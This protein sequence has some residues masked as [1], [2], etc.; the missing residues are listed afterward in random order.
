MTLADRIAVLSGGRVMQY[1]TPDEIYHRPAAKFVA[2]FTGSPAMNFLRG[3]LTAGARHLK[4]A[5]CE[6]H[7]RQR[8]PAQ[9]FG[10][11]RRWWNLASG[12]RIFRSPRCA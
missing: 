5:R 4:S 6:C 11:Q 8:F 3:A 10:S 12:R 1:A 9:P 2:G 7:Y